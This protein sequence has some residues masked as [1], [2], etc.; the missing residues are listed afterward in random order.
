MAAVSAIQTLQNS[1]SSGTKLK[2]NVSSVFLSFAKR[3]S[4]M[5]ARHFLKED[6]P[7]VTYANPHVSFRIRRTVRKTVE[8]C[9]HVN[10]A[11]STRTAIPIAKRTSADI[12]KDFFKTAA[13]A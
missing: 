11:D 12:R 7:A 6:L 4:D 13:E 5:G 3:N 10:F 9:L 2:P 1:L 8:P